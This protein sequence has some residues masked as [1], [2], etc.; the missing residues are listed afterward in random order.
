MD[1]LRRFRTVLRL[2]RQ[3][4]DALLMFSSGGLSL[5]EKGV[6]AWIARWR[7]V[8]TLLFIRAGAVM[9]QARASSIR[10]FF[11]RAI[12]GGADRLLCQ[13]ESW[14]D[15]FVEYCGYEQRRCPIVPNWTA[16]EEYLRLGSE[17]RYAD[18]AIARILF[19]GWLSEA[20]GVLELLE[21]VRILV[22][23][24]Q[25]RNLIVDICGDGGAGLRAREVA[26]AHGLPVRFHGWVEGDLKRSLFAEASIFTLPSY[27]EGF[28]NAVVEAMASGL[29][30]VVTPVGCIPDFVV[31][32]ENGLLVPPQD[33]VALADALEQLIGR[34]DE[35][36]RLGRGAWR[37]A[38]SKFTAEAA[39]A[40]L[41]TLIDE[42]VDERRGGQ[43]SKHGAKRA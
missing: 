8:G 35:R 10:R 15:F 4:P 18:D 34:A 38:R 28:P 43:V 12:T 29:P 30:V 41:A 40:R 20:K 39:A 37:V 14:R 5:F 31:N 36:S 27:N 19:V 13:G 32:N 2:L 42:V 1:A 9:T 16:E 23:E 24:R 22:V 33:A 26:E 25:R 11:F 6:Y 21:A 17:R 3:Q 7:G